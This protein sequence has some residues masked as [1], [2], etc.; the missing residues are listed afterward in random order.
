MAPIAKSPA[1][2]EVKEQKIKEL[3]DKLEESAMANQMALQ[4][5]INAVLEDFARKAD[6]QLY[7]ARSISRISPLATYRYA[8]EELAWSG[9]AH[10]RSF[11]KSARSYMEEYTRYADKMRREKRDE[12]MPTAYG[13]LED[14]DGFVLSIVSFRSYKYIPLD[15]SALAPFVDKRPA[16]S[17]SIVNAFWDILALFSLNLAFLTGSLLRFH[18]YDVR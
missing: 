16:V 4:K 10:H 3:E 14:D 6:A 18:Y 5:N 9:Y 11:I 8:V 15:S 2:R 17:Q 12:A 7:L 1:S 13:M